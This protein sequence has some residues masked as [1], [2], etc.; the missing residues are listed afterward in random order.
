M[1]LCCLSVDWVDWQSHTKKER[2][3]HTGVVVAYCG[4]EW[5]DYVSESVGRRVVAW[6]N[7]KGG[8]ERSERHGHT[9]AKR[10][11]FSSNHFS[12][13]FPFFLFSQSFSFPDTLLLSHHPLSISNSTI[14]TRNICAHLQWTQIKPTQNSIHFIILLSCSNSLLL[15]ISSISYLTPIITLSWLCIMHKTIFIY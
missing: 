5:S 1:V 7:E 8:E 15:H 11:S 3:Q 10:N 6:W 12:P 14:P 4:V 13:S 2:G 9:K